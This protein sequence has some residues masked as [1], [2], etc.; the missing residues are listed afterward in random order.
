M[1][2]VV[3]RG[4]VLKSG[5]GG[6]RGAIHRA[7]S[8]GRNEPSTSSACSDERNVVKF[9]RRA[10]LGL[11]VFGAVLRGSNRPES[12]A[13]GAEIIYDKGTTLQGKTLST[14]A[15]APAGAEGVAAESQETSGIFASFVVPLRWRC[16][17]VREEA[18]DAGS[19]YVWSGFTDPVDGQGI[20]DRAEV[21]IL[22]YP[23]ALEA[24]Y[25][26]RVYKSGTIEALGGGLPGGVLKENL[27]RADIFRASTRQD[28]VGTTYYDWELAASPQACTEEE[29]KLLGICPYESVTLLAVAAKD[30]KLVTLTIES[31]IASFQRYTKDIRNAMRSFK[32]D[33]GT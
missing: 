1:F 33:A 24:G 10:S 15:M 30:D 14:R 17:E 23:R 11:S 3:M 19:R 6:C 25:L 4:T 26:D 13:F 16:G 29:R 8:G 9:S 12:E 7:R 2:E 5:R 28:A 20:L 31:K 22:D 21:A 32:L 27:R 18:V